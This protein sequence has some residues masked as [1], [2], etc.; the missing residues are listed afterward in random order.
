MHS[1]GN[2]KLFVCFSQGDRDSC[3]GCS[4]PAEER[5]PSC[6]VWYRQRLRGWIVLPRRP[7]GEREG[8]ERTGT[9]GEGEAA[10]A[11]IHVSRTR[12]KHTYSD[13]VHI[14]LLGVFYVSLVSQPIKIYDI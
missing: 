11:E 13:V 8:E 9:S 5:P 4:Q 2:R 10:A 12:R 6:C 3:P 7:Q 14:R 1:V